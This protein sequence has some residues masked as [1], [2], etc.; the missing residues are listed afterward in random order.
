MSRLKKMRYARFKI[1]YNSSKCIDDWR[2]KMGFITR[3]NIRHSQQKKYK[4]LLRYS[5]FFVF[6][7]S[8]AIIYFSYQFSVY[9]FWFGQFVL[10]LLAIVMIIA[11]VFRFFFKYRGMTVIVQFIYCVLAG[12]SLYSGWLM[13]DTAG[14]LQSNFYNNQYRLRVLTRNDSSIS[15]LA[16]INSAVSAPVAIDGDYLDLLTKDIIR[17]KNYTLTYKNVNNYMSAADE[18]M[19]KDVAAIVMNSAEEAIVKHKYPTFEQSIKS[20]YEFTNQTPE[21][22]TLENENTDYLTV[23]YGITSKMWDIRTDATISSL[24]LFDISRN[25]KQQ[26]P[27]DVS[28]KET[29]YRNNGEIE[30]TIGELGLYGKKTLIDAVEKQTN[31]K[32][33]H[34]IIADYDKLLPLM[35]VINVIT[36][37]NEHEFVSRQNNLTFAAG[38][39][40]LDKEQVLLYGSEMNEGY[41]QRQRA[42]VNAILKQTLQRLDTY[43]RPDILAVLKQSIKTNYNLNDALKILGQLL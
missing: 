5:T 34:M 8:A 15:V 30:S 27:I 17:N 16:Q 40:T 9:R 2:L 22:M 31:Q 41:Q 38:T 11:C 4:K 26:I 3:Q 23:L 10:L 25:G 36:F 18:L 43:F 33:Q 20:I 29:I 37:E 14:Q 35:D 42:I 19:N 32:I 12:V 21:T 24:S 13:Y 7:F 39:L 6:I 1:L 28:A